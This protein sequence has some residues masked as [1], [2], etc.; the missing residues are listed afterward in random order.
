MLAIIRHHGHGLAM[1]KSYDP[2]AYLICLEAKI[3]GIEPA[4]TRMLELPSALNF[5]QLHEVCRPH[6]GGPTATCTSFMSAA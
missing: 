6:S 1:P 3:V 2:Y 4:I 5:A